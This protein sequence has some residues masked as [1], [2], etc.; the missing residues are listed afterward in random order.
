[1]MVD[2]QLL[3]NIKAAQDAGAS[4]ASAEDVMRMYEFIKQI[5]KENED[6]KEELEDMDIAIS[7]IITDN[8]KKYWLTVK[9]GD[10]DFGEG[11]VDNPSFTMSSTLEVGAG[12]LM[13]EVD[14]T[15]AYMAGDIT[16]EGN[17]QDAMA[18][19]EIVELALEAYEDLA[20]DL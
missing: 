13:G 10:L 2:E 18:F 6:L 7:M 1:K 20:E 12:I 17:L 19:Q 14:A 9:E 5:S 15:S 8:D 11:D 4:A 16:V 3:K